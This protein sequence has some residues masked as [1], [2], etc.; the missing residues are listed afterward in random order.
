METTLSFGK[1][2]S[3]SHKC[4]RHRLCHRLKPQVDSTLLSRLASRL[5]FLS[6]LRPLVWRVLVLERALEDASEG[7]I[8]PA[9]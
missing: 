3:L 2:R 9:L 4:L 8:G 1:A 5:G 6:R 7:H